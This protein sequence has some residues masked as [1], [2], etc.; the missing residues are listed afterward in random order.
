MYFLFID[1]SKQDKIDSYQQTRVQT[2]G[3]VPKKPGGLFWVDP[4][5]KTRQ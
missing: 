5:K 3:Y 1:F 4:P 2:P